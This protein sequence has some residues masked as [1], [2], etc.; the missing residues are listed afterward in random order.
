[1]RG[2]APLLALTA[3]GCTQL[4]GGEAPAL[5]R[6]PGIEH[7]A[8]GQ[9]LSEWA[10][11]FVREDLTHRQ[12]VTGHTGHHLFLMVLTEGSGATSRRTMAHLSPLAERHRGKGFLLAE[13]PLVLMATD[14]TQAERR[15][16]RELFEADEL[17]EAMVP[18]A[19]LFDLGGE[20]I[21]RLRWPEVG[22]GPTSG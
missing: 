11:E 8:P 18:Q 20:I 6:G 10:C 1:M 22:D 14:G 12:D 16:A 3:L 19:A 9:P 5:P 15:F 2:L 21:V 4:Q 7:L 13:I 17:S